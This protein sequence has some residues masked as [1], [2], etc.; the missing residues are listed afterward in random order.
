MGR[1]MFKNTTQFFNIA[2]AATV[3][4]LILVIFG[5]PAYAV[6]WTESPDAGDLPGTAQVVRG[7]ANQ[8]LN[9][10]SGTIANTQDVD[11]YK[12]QISAPN[13]FSAST[14]GGDSPPFDAVLALFDASGLGVYFND[15]GVFND[16][17][18]SLPAGH[19]L[20][21]SSPGIYYLAIFSDETLPFSGAGVSENDLIF[22]V[23]QPPF[24]EVLGPTSSGG[25][26]PLSGWATDGMFT[27]GA[28]YQIFL[29]GAE[30][31]ESTPGG[32]DLDGTVK[33]A[34]G[35]DICAMVLAS[36]QFM[37]SCNPVGVF[38]LTDLPRETDNTVKR[39]IYADGFFPKIDILTGSTNEAVVMTQSGV[40]PSYNTAY[41]PAVVPGSAGKWIDISGKVLVQNIQTPICAMVLANGQHT[42]SCDA[43]GSYALNIP[44]DTNGQFKLQVYADGFAPTIQTFDEFSAVNDVRM[45]R[46]SE[47]Q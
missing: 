15:D 35:I 2:Q 41:S 20:G 16:G 40:C 38:S 14:T 36:G 19:P 37:F 17:N 42:F 18:P 47:C 43:T 30:S 25:S 4:A 21:P 9:T 8:A 29:T 28:G 33:T 5:S 32:V 6:D 11:L 44:L 22:P 39:Q 27:L 31:A 46:A 12:I 3:T 34:G 26:A 1:I 24:N 13:A 23:A 10:I 7:P 45:A